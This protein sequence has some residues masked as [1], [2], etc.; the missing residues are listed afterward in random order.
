MSL[1]STVSIDRRRESGGALL[2]VLW[3][4]AALAAIA[5]SLATS[6]RGETER[7]ATALDSV[8][9]HFLAA[10]A[11]DRAL[12]YM[13]WGPG[14]KNPDGTPQYFASGTPYL[15][16]E[17]PTGQA[18]VRIM[19]ESAKINVNSAPPEELYRLFVAAGA[20]AERAQEITLAIID[21]RSAAP[22]NAP[23]AFDQYYLSLP[24]SFPARHA[25]FEEIEELLLVKGMTQ[26][27]FYGGYERSGEGRLVPHVGLRDCLTVWGAGAFDVNT[28]EPVVMAAAGIPAEV[29]DSIVAARKIEPFRN[30]EQVAAVVGD[31][32]ARARLRVGG[33]AIFT[34]RATARLRL[35]N[36]TLSDERRSVAA[37]VKF[38]GPRYPERL[39]VLRWYDNVWVQ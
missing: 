11:I 9:T 36:G 22:G 12:L 35:Q 34:L 31:N 19:P 15:A 33:N 16:F 21:W 5:F 10:G 26:E 28:V 1:I 27:L 17:F 24:S 30:M 29:I 6:V 39:H 37:T 20:D 38:L 14:H 25:S 4:S 32:P 3:L 2:S 23:T 18:E 8:R 7:T 13:Q